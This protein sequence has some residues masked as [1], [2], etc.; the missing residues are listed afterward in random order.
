MEER[1]GISPY[2]MGQIVKT[3]GIMAEQ[4][5]HG[6]YLYNPT[7]QECEIVLE[8]IMESI[9]KCKSKVDTHV[10][11]TMFKKWIKDEFRHG[12]LVVGQIY[13]GLVLQGS[14]WVTWT[15]EGSVPNWLKAAVMEHVG[16]LPGQGQVFKAKNDEVQ[17]YEI[18]ENPFLNLPERYREAKIPFVVTPIIYN[19]KW[20]DFRLVQCRASGEL[21]P[22]PAAFYDIIDIKEIGSDGYPMG[23][24]SRDEKGSVLI[25]KNE[26]SALAVSRV[27]MTEKSLPVLRAL[28]GMKFE[29][30]PL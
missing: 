18:S 6:K 3:A 9:K 14:G 21:I 24:S 20:Q 11:K 22:L 2:R 10:S 27:E 17:Q 16:E 26:N 23:P 15:E 19:T 8:L 7:Y 5:T 30:V 1:K 12:G 4:L 29:E 25:W 28:K 13:G